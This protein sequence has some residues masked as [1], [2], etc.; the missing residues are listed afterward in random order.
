MALIKCPKCGKEFSDRAQTCP[1]CGMS[2]NEIRPIIDAT[3]KRAEL[4]DRITRIVMICLSSFAYIMIIM[5]LI[6]LRTK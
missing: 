4:H 2:I 3:I 1:Q 6:Y 5:A